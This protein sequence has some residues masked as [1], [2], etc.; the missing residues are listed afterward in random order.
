MKSSQPRSVAQK[1]PRKTESLIRPL[2]LQDAKLEMENVSRV[3]PQPYRSRLRSV[4]PDRRRRIINMNIFKTQRSFT[5]HQCIA[6]LGP[7]VC[8]PVAGGGF[9]ASIPRY[10]VC[11]YEKAMLCW[12]CS[13]LCYAR[14]AMPCHVRSSRNISV[15]AETLRTLHTPS[16]Q[17]YEA[18]ARLKK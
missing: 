15:V 6:F 14:R 2:V 11:S 16:R 7:N 8:S 9:R 12:V 1:S 3:S 4:M 10:L 13:L 5:I 17:L 18:P